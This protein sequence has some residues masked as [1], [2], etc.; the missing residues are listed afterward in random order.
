MAKPFTI[1]SMPSKF[2]LATM[3][4]SSRPLAAL[5]GTAMRITG[6]SWRASRYASPTT[7]SSARICVA[8]SFGSRARSRSP[9]AGT[10]RSP[11][12]PITQ[13]SS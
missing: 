10:S 2:S 12:R 4:A 13:S 3:A 1:F 8:H 6:L 5:M 7:L 9:S 11:S